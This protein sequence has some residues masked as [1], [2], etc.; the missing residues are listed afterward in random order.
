MKAVVPLY[1]TTKTPSQW[2]RTCLLNLPR[3]AQQ[4]KTASQALSG[5]LFESGIGSVLFRKE[6]ENG[7]PK[8][9]IFLQN[10]PLAGWLFPYISACGTAVIFL[11]AYKE[12]TE[13]TLSNSVFYLP[14]N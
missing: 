5:M 10:I 4:G 1:G 6:T 11:C 12:S 7:T 2:G 13:K 14:N 9:Q 8:A 3:F